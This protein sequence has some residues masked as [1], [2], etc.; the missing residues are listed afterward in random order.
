MALG[1][2]GVGK[3]HWWLLV[4]G[5]VRSLSIVILFPVVDDLTCLGET[6]E[7]VY[8]K[9]LIAELPVEALQVAIVHRLAGFN[10][11]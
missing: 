8:V 10:E 5:A 7:P 9:A 1:W 6:E 4:Q 11:V 3:D 2:Y